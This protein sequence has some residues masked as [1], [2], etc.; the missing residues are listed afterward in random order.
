MIRRTSWRH[1]RRDHMEVAGQAAR[2]MAEELGWDEA[3][4]QSELF[5]YRTRFGASGAVAPHVSTSS[6]GSSNGH[7]DVRSHSNALQLDG[8][9]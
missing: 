5:E 4:T 1:Y 8:V 7:S 6:N 9:D 3:R 2:W